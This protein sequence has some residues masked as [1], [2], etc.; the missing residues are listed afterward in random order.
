MRLGGMRCAYLVI[1]AHIGREAGLGQYFQ[2]VQAWAA[3]VGR[4]ARGITRCQPVPPWG[5][6]RG[7]REASGRVRD[8][9]GHW[10]VPYRRGQRFPGPQS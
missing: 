10:R 3:A 5:A 6:P 2:P 8:S 1:Y 4:G 7:L 9:S